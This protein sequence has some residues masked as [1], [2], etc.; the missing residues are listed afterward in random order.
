[1]RSTLPPRAA[2]LLRRMP[3]MT[4]Y[5]GMELLLLSLVAV[6][7]A[8]LVWAGLAP[9]GPLGTWQ[10]SM[11]LPPPSAA[12]QNWTFDPFFR[13]DGASGPAVV[14]SLPLTLHGVREDRASGRGSAIIGTPDGQQASYVVGE[15]I[16]PGVRLQKVQFDSVTLSR[17]GVEEQLFLDQSS[18]AGGAS[19][20]KTLSAAP[21]ARQGAGS[22]PQPSR[23]PGSAGAIPPLPRTLPRPP[24]G[25][26][27]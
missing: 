23:S 12:A 13:L 18:P 1:M 14:T 20:A 8:R 19:A 2:R 15:E 10:A 3:R 6:Q 22:R 21:A 4:V 5:S 7:A 11:P 24:L 16:M 27:Q 25:K 26:N 9:I 17:N